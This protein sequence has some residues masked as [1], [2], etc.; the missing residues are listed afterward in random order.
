MLNIS[1]RIVSDFY[2]LLMRALFTIIFFV[3]TFSYMFWDPYILDKRSNTAQSGERLGC[4]VYRLY[5]LWAFASLMYVSIR[6]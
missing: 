6:S 2:V 5:T 3:L 4:V 1:G